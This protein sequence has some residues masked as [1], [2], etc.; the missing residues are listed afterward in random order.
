MLGKLSTFSLYLTLG[1]KSSSRFLPDVISPESTIIRLSLIGGKSKTLAAVL[2][3]GFGF[4][5]K[6]I[7]LSTY[8][9]F[10]EIEPLLGVENN[11][12]FCVGSFRSGAM[13]KSNEAYKADSL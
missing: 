1:L 8:L 3:F 2:P 13:L 11:D 5:K 6:T 10:G 4:F 7:F 9:L 12:D